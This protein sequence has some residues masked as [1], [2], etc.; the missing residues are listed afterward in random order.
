MRHSS[1]R[2]RPNGTCAPD[3]EDALGTHT[4]LLRCA[5]LRE[6]KMPGQVRLG[7]PRPPPKRVRAIAQPLLTS[8][9]DEIPKLFDRRRAL[10]PRKPTG[11]GELEIEADNDIGIRT[12][13]SD[14]MR[15]YFATITPRLQTRKAP[16]PDLR[17]P[18]PGPSSRLRSGPIDGDSAF[19]RLPA[20]SLVSPSRSTWQD[21][22]L[23][24]FS[25]G[26]APE[27]C[28]S[29]GN[30]TVIGCESAPG[31]V[32]ADEFAP[33]VVVNLGTGWR[34]ENASARSWP[35]WTVAPHTEFWSGTPRSGPGRLGVAAGGG[36]VP[37][38][39]GFDHLGPHECTRVRRVQHA[40]HGSPIGL[41]G[42]V[43][44]GAPQHPPALLPPRPPGPWPLSGARHSWAN[45]AGSQSLS[46]S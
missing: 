38:T 35:E 37:Q 23:D 41:R 28:P 31:F 12:R 8:L 11:E 44:G 20:A 14:N 1:D 15:D 4:L 26:A 30:R 25:H 22:S 42:P 21:T 24:R 27:D 13:I 45:E 3:L 6:T 2:A 17:E 46:A 40:H 19:H 16:V 39:V 33:F 36:R 32:L 18:D 10:S 5:L 7:L 34:A 43:V 9:F 29:S